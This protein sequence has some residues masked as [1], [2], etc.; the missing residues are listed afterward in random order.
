MGGKVSRCTNLSV[1][2]N[3]LLFCKAL[4]FKA[5]R[6]LNEPMKWATDSQKYQIFAST[7]SS[8]CSLG[9]TN[10]NCETHLSSVEKYWLRN[11]IQ[12]GWMSSTCC[13]S[14]ARKLVTNSR[15]FKNML[16]SRMHC[17]MFSSVAFSLMA[18]SCC[19]WHGFVILWPRGQTLKEHFNI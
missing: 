12:S 5:S 14:R 15:A 18:A 13:W 3:P 6:P 2:P 1:T 19:L 17:R 7:L 16:Y 10:S 11:A 9:W 8:L 4:L